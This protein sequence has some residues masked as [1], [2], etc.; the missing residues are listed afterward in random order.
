MGKWEHAPPPLLSPQVGYLVYETFFDPDRKQIK[1][2]ENKLTDEKQTGATFEA[3][4]REGSAKSCPE[5]EI[6]LKNKQA[7]GWPA[8]LAGPDGEF[9]RPETLIN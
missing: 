5:S 2:V 7:P 8:G 4:S 9:S 3:A 1:R 6:C